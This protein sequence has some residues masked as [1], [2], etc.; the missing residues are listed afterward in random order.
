MDVSIEKVQKS[1]STSSAPEEMQDVVNR[2]SHFPRASGAH[3]QNQSQCIFGRICD[4]NIS[5]VQEIAIPEKQLEVIIDSC[6]QLSRFLLLERLNQFDDK[7]IKK[8]DLRKIQ[9]NSK[10]VDLISEYLTIL[11]KK[12]NL[13][14]L[15]IGEIQKNIILE[16]PNSINTL[17]Y[18]TIKN[19]HSDATLK[20]PNS[21]NKITMLVI[22]RI[23]ASANLS[24]PTLF[25]SLAHLFIGFIF[26]VEYV[27]YMVLDKVMGIFFKSD[28]LVEENSYWR[29]SIFKISNQLN[30]L[31][32][33]WIGYILNHVTFELSASLPN[34]TTLEIAGM[35]DSTFTLQKS[36]PSLKTLILGTICNSTLDLSKSL[37]NL[38]TFLIEEFGSLTLI[39][40]ENLTDIS[41][42][43]RDRRSVIIFPNSLTSLTTL[44]IKSIWS[45]TRAPKDQILPIGF[46]E[47]NTVIILPVLPSLTMLDIGT[48]ES[49]SVLI[50]PESLPKLTTL[51]IGHIYSKSFLILSEFLPQ[52]TTL[53]IET[54]ERGA[55]LTLPKV[56]TLFA[57]WK[58]A[59]NA[60][61]IP[62]H[63]LATLELGNINPN[64]IC[65]R[66][67]MLDGYGWTKPLESYH[68]EL[69]R[70]NQKEVQAHLC[71][72][73]QS[74][75]AHK[76]LSDKLIT[77]FGYQPVDPGSIGLNLKDFRGEIAILDGLIVDGSD[78]ASR[79]EKCFVDQDMGLKIAIAV[80][81]DL[82]ELILAFGDLGS[83][84]IESKENS[85]VWWRQFKGVVSN[86]SGIQAAL[87]Q[88]A[89]TLAMRI[90]KAVLQIEKYK[91][92]NI[93]LTGQ[94]LGGSLA[95]FV[96]L[97][98]ELTTLCYNAVP[99]G[100]GLQH[101]I[102]DEKL[103]KA[104][105]Y[106]THMTVESDYVSDME[107]IG[108]VD[109]ALSYLGVRT[110]GNFGQRFS[111]PTAYSKRQQTHS[112]VL[113]S[114]MNYL[115]LDKKLLPKDLKENHPELLKHKSENQL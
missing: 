15:M 69:Q 6:E 11:F 84:S 83:L 110:P 91:N 89:E 64:A 47:R 53:V 20:I 55:T 58:M 115:N 59:Y 24:L 56:F 28:R 66:S 46:K 113:G 19:I 32:K 82:R 72:I 106:I 78:K 27:P 38:E 79:T 45:L 36:L 57:L 103:K 90:I 60:I 51:N 108:I 26:P 14:N 70:L 48:I 16:L 96:G 63:P 31:T 41:S 25:D 74:S 9:V 61:S 77:P 81:E 111:I 37:D 35:R 44:K 12:L 5:E 76:S 93:I 2:E 105:S 34:L 30:G 33:L 80:N 101:L 18:L 75:Y 98:N 92:F 100:R 87:Y 62:N 112:F 107:G 94:S 86:L 39:S 49:D 109:G 52:L 102:G 99:L 7:R 73:A 95:Q 21:F 10:T 88:Q 42:L 3:D 8:L 65:K 97:R 17:T 50:L 40:I 22:E 4:A 68:Y 29:N 104:D 114:T 13:I 54:V 85:T 1:R 71:Y 43:R 67:D 23:N